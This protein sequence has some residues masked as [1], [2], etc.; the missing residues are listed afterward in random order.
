ML[1]VVFVV[2]DLFTFLSLLQGLCKSPEMLVDTSETVLCCNREEHNFK[3]IFLD[4]RD[5]RV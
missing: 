3:I 4:Q 5:R 2:H 1:N